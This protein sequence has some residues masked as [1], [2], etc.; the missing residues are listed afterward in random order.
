M[1]STLDASPGQL[2]TPA[3]M[4]TPPEREATSNI[5]RTDISPSIP[6]LMASTTH[7]PSEPHSTISLVTY[8][9]GQSSPS[10]STLTKFP[11]MI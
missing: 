2:E 3:L 8:V 4:V 10:T 9:G 11:S 1:S 7:N 5:L 6:D